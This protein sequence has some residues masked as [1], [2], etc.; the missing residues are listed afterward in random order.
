MLHRALCLPEI[1]PGRWKC[2]M[3]PKDGS[4]LPHP[5]S[6]GVYRKKSRR[7]GGSKRLVGLQPEKMIFRPDDI[8]HGS[9][10][11]GHI[12][13]VAIFFYRHHMGKGTAFGGAHFFNHRIKGI[14][15]FVCF[16]VCADVKQVFFCPAVFSNNITSR[17]NG[18][19]V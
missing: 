6:D 8:V 16:G 18:T 10:A 7:Q 19:A 1:E 12:D 17:S 4:F 2:A 9:H 13:V 11:Q 5:E 14:L 15:G 3:K